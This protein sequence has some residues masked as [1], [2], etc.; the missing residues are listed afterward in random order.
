MDYL[1]GVNIGTT[2]TKAVLYDQDFNALASASRSHHL[3]RD[4]PEMLEEDPDEVFDTVVDTLHEVVGKADL[5][6]GTLRGVSFSSMMH[7]LIGLNRVN[8]PLTRVL[9]WGDNRA[10]KYAAE[11]KQ[12]GA[13]L[14]I[15]QRTGMPTHPM[16]LPYKLIW[17]KNEHPEIF[18]RTTCW[19]GIKDYVFWRLFGVLKTDISS[20][21]ASGLLNL[22]ELDWDKETLKLIGIS[23][24]QLPQLSSPY[25]QVR[26]LRSQ[27]AAKIGLPMDTPFIL[28]AADGPMDNL[29]VG[30]LDQGTTAITIGD[31]S[32]A[33]RVITDQPRFDIE[34][35]LFCYALDEEHWVV[36]GPI[37]AGN[38]VF[39]WAG[40]KLFAPEKQLANMMHEESLD[41]VAKIAKTIPAG[42][43]GLIFH[44][45]LNGERAPMWNANARGSFFGLTPHHTRGHMARAVLE[46]T[47]YELYAI[48]LT[49]ETVVGEPRQIMATGNFS[50]FGLWRQILADVFQSPVAIPQEQDSRTLAAV[51]MGMK[52]LGMIKKIDVIKEH[53]KKAATCQPDPVTY[54]IY[55]SLVPI[56]VQLSSDLQQEYNAI[57]DFQHKYCHFN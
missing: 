8:K 24:D 42:S 16:A 56:Y 26:G 50:R 40:D 15:Y 7:S 36:G 14:K 57:A 46:G 19:L 5:N 43:D 31:T 37:N 1:I 10:A 35:R 33:V 20:A 34:G 51:V 47:V 13:G 23:A 12:N 17:L 18:E 41:V 27:I 48:S 3:F 45:F 28:G 38:T 4:E 22:K 54:D 55:Q 6:N 29:G 11:M 49:L 39:S 21:S 9:T 25:E 2:C 32:G 30:A 53:L 52:S 44:P